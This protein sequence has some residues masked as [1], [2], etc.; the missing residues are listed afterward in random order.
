MHTLKYHKGCHL[1]K[2]LSVK[3]AD[4]WRSEPP[5]W[6]A[7]PV[8]VDTLGGCPPW[9]SNPRSWHWLSWALT[10]R[11]LSRGHWTLF[12]SPTWPIV[13]K[14]PE[15]WSILVCVV[16]VLLTHFFFESATLDIGCFSKKEGSLQ[17][18][19]MK[20][21]LIS[22]T[23][24]GIKLWLWGAIP[25]HLFLLFRPADD[26]PWLP[27]IFNLSAISSLCEGWS[28]DIAPPI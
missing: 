16:M 5:K 18:L 9:V 4:K 6:A 3:A 24:G 11:L 28:F 2:H 19:K 23:E 27:T 20:F 17:W 25:S 13:S 22:E 26:P 1:S 14:V 15:G 7:Q 8:G 10:T 12:G 21:V